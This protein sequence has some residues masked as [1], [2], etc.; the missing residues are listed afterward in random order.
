M[1][2]SPV[3]MIRNAPIVGVRGVQLIAGII[4]CYHCSYPIIYESPGL[5]VPPSFIPPITS[6]NHA[7]Y[8]K[9]LLFAPQVRI[10]PECKEGIVGNVLYKRINQMPSIRRTPL[11]A[12]S[13]IE[14]VLGVVRCPTCYDFYC[15]KGTQESLP[16]LTD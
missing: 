10:C 12:R 11:L 7:D 15:F 2:S 5:D 13:G 3:P 16:Q 1:K 8:N 4:Y 6:K 14:I 9:K